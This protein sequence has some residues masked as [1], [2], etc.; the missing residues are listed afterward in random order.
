ML[1]HKRWFAGTSG[2]LA[3]AS[4]LFLIACSGEGSDKLPTTGATLGTDT[5]PPTLIISGQKPEDATGAFT[6]TFK[7]SEQVQLADTPSATSPFTI[8]DIDV[9]PAEVTKSDWTV[10]AAQD[11][12]SQTEV[13]VKFTPPEG[14]GT[15]TVS[16]AGNKFADIAG[17]VNSSSISVEQTYNIAVV[18]PVALRVG[19]EGTASAAFAPLWDDYNGT[20]DGSDAVTDD[21]TFAQS[22]TFDTG[23]Q[24]ELIT[25]TAHQNKYDSAATAGWI[26]FIDLAQAGVTTP[27][28]LTGKTVTLRVRVPAGSAVN[29]AKLVFRTATD[30][31]QGTVANIATAD[32]WTTISYTFGG[33]TDYTSG[34]FSITQVTKIGVQVV[35]RTP[36]PTAN[37]AGTSL[38]IDSLT[39]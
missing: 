24:S 19:F 8:D 39:W 5:A 11:G 26:F 35:C 37:I 31:S 12:S 3:I 16:V 23:A 14:E 22:A 13:T 38:L 28:N 29:G 2:V 27:V 7:S 1:N 21:M 4:T 6:L 36:T 32:T 30:Q 34:G 9:S 10:V 17:N 33:A 20:W 25:A 18:D 15:V